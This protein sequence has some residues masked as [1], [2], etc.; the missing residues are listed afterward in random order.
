MDEF[1]KAR[2]NRRGPDGID[3]EYNLA[4]E[5]VDVVSITIIYVYIID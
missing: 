4:I 2:M 5:V 1:V 3:G